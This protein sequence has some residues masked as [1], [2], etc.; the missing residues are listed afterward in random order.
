MYKISLFLLFSIFRERLDNLDLQAPLESVDL[1][2][3]LAQWALK[4][5][6]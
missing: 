5:P 6:L 3:K 2:V 1:S 4:A